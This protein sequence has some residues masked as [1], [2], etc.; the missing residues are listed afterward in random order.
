MKHDMMFVNVI[1]VMMLVVYSD[2]LT[3][4]L[5]Y[6]PSPALEN[7]PVTLTCSYT[8]LQAGENL[9][10]TTLTVTH[11]NESS[12]T[13]GRII[14][15]ECSTF[16]YIDSALYSYSCANGTLK[17][18]IRN[19][20]R[21]NNEETWTWVLVTTN[22][23]EVASI[24][25][26]VT[27]PITS[28][29]LTKPTESTVTMNA[30]TSETFIC[31]TSGGLPKAT[32]K[33][34]KVTGNT[35]SQSGTEIVSSVSS[36]TVSVLDN[37]KLVES[38]LTFTA[39]S[40]D[41]QLRI[42]C[43]ASNVAGIQRVSAT[44]MLDV[45][46]APSDPPV[47]EGYASG[48]TY[49]MIE[50]S[51]ESLACSSTGGN[52]LAILTW[53]CFNN[54]MSNPTVQESTIKRAVQWTARRNENARCT[55][56][57]LH[58]SR[59]NQPKSAFINVNILYPPST[60]LFR[61]SN[62]DVGNS[63]RIVRDST[64]TVECD[65]SGNPS[66]TTSD[67]T[68]RKGFNVVST[69]SVL[70]WPGGVI[71]GDEG[72][73][74][75]TVETTMTPSDQS[76]NAQVAMI[77]STVA[78]TVLYPPKLLTLHRRNAVEGSS[79]FLQ[80]QYTDGNLRTTKAMITRAADGVT[81]SGDSHT[82]LSINRADA[83][84]Y[85]CTVENSMDPTGAEIQTGRDTSDFEINVWYNT[86][87]TRFDV[88]AFPNQN[89]VTINEADHIVLVCEVISNPPN[90]TVRLKKKNMATIL[91]ERNN[92]FDVDFV[93]QNASCSDAAIY[94]CSA[95]NNYTYMERAPSKELQLLVRCS[96]RPSDSHDYLRRNLTG[97]VHGNVTF[98]FM[99][100]AYP[101]PMFEWQ[102]WNGTSYNIV[103]GDKY[104]ITSLDLFTSL[105]ILNIQ[106]DDFDLYI[107]KVSNGIQPP[108]QE[109]FYL[110]P[111]DVPRCPT[112]F[113]VLSKSTTLA[114]VQW[115]GGFNGGLQQTFVLFYKKRSD[116]KYFPIYVPEDKET[117]IYNTELTNLEDGQIYDVI[118]Y[119]M[120]P[121]GPC[122]ENKSIEIVTDK[123]SED[124]PPKHA[125]IIG[126]VVGGSLG[127]VVAVIVLVLFLGRKNTLNC[128]LSRK[129]D[130]Q[131]GQNGQ[132]ADN[133]KY[134]AAVTY[135]VVSATK[136]KPVYDALTVGNNGL[137]NSHVY[138]P[139]EELNQKSHAYYENVRREDPVYNN[140]V[141]KKTGQT[142]L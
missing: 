59:P 31:R 51:T 86:S 9:S 138:T 19:I 129:K 81:W 36:P 54:Q 23:T 96:P 140:T 69:D 52:P 17:W 99:A 78:I 134:N 64:Q 137:E 113:T 66:P 75:C 48:S 60:P 16:G 39:L 13:K 88:S 65:S 12:R 112:H 136:E 106:Q 125:P 98:S 71:I 30:G 24:N 117:L 85:R 32:I 108:L 126:G 28:V 105:T 68:W 37:L 43:S 27:V 76:K 40:T 42:C 84:L 45:R 139:L 34:F 8:G 95:F 7:T 14:L 72:N 87:I 1:F 6:G 50:N 26:I 118:L 120:N 3:L 18:T 90:S 53:S 109:L 77:S 80:C 119:S 4:N 83:G 124:I 20:N 82:F 111:Q 93:I 11:R 63:I 67:F 47:I 79:Y 55:C 130:I 92:V 25:L 97:T 57:A 123:I 122:V 15:P 5:T 115:N 41:N 142:V 135:E 116:S 38:T 89:I 131:S 100:V 44:K 74:T 103:H 94:T 2:T 62:I 10:H 29:S 22:Q 91:M 49:S 70:N 21:T 73:Y 58:V 133:P 46:Y 114:T 110:G 33:W 56:T 101:P 107:L 104:V 121:I 132:G 61:V 102:M 127:V 35:C 128:S 141:L